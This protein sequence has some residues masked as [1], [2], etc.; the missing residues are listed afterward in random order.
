MVSE[1]ENPQDM[2]LGVEDDKWQNSGAGE[3]EYRTTTCR[4]A[5]EVAIGVE[6]FQ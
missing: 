5:V 4:V 2:I 1:R 3:R 6:C